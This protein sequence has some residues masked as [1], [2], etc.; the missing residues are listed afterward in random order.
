MD[1]AFESVCDC[2]VIHEETVAQVQEAMPDEKVLL[3]TAELFKVFGDL[4]RIKIISA[5]LCAELCV[6]DIAA[7][8]SMSKSAISHQL[9]TLRQAKL[10]KTRREG[11]IVYYSLADAHVSTILAQGLEHV[12]E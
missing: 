5:L 8:L 6:C 1:D 4:T 3:S 11:N 10:V 9:R 7:L 2:T 12:G